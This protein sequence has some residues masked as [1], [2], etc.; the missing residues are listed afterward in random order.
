MSTDFA[1]AEYALVQEG[2]KEMSFLLKKISCDV[3]VCGSGAAGLRAGIEAFERGT[4]VLIIGQSRF[5]DAHTRLAAGGINAALGVVTQKDNWLVHAADTFEEGGKI[6]VPQMVEILARNANDA[7]I[8]LA[9]FGVKFARN[10]RGQ[11]KQRIYGAQTY[12]RTCYVGDYTGRAILQALVRKAK[13]L[14]VKQIDNAYI[15]HLFKSGGKVLGCFA[16]DFKKGEFLV[17]QAKSV[18]LAMGG[19]SRVYKNSSSRPF[20]NM[21]YGSYLALQNGLKLQDMEMVQ[22]HPTGM[23]WPE[24]AVGKL[25]TEAVR[26]EGGTLLNASGERLMKKYSPKMLELSARDVVARAIFTEIVEG[27]GTKNRGVFLDLTRVPKEK[28]LERLPDTFKQFERYQKIDISRE[29]MEVS[30]TSHYSM[31]GIAVNPSDCSAGL[32]GLFACGEATG[33]L[34]GANRLGGNSLAETL[35]FG[36]IAG[37]NASDFAKQN[38]MLEIGEIEINSARKE[39]ESFFNRGFTAPQTL[40]TQLQEIM[41]E[42]AGV[43]K[44]GEKLREGLEKLQELKENI[45][46]MNV[47]EGLKKNSEL[48]IALDTTSLVLVAQAVLESAL[49]RKESRGAHYR[50]DFPKTL[51]SWQANIFAELKGG[52]LKLSKKMILRGSKEFERAVH[53]HYDRK[54]ELWE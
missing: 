49:L 2:E 44:D 48:V 38:K 45:P 18:V 15:T 1:V 5:G 8:E 27:R 53:A 40:R 35:V 9:N 30:P 25:V 46:K 50:T 51:G 20:E 34:H 10:E 11:I 21:G 32:S 14:G 37:V 4:N 42:C 31:G 6:G 16:V 54:F 43:I 22:F 7:V 29:K 39:I 26:S 12:P 3:L 28:I 41:W 23:T 36:K 13:K 24:S 33:G 52:K 17:L 19:Y 47:K